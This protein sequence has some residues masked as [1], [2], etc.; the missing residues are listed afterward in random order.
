MVFSKKKKKTD[1]PDIAELSRRIEQ[2]TEEKEFY[3]R[4][5]HSLLVFLK[6][7]PLDLKEVD[8]AGFS[9]HIDELTKRIL[10]VTPPVKSRSFVEKSKKIISNF[11]NRHKQV[12]G[13]RE[14]EFKEIIEL[15]T[16]AM[17]ELGNENRDYH[18]EIYKQTETIEKLTLLDDI[19][20]IKKAIKEQVEHIR[21]KVIEKQEKENRRIESLSEKVS[22]LETELKRA[23]TKSLIDGLTGIY[24]RMAF[25]QKIKEMV[26]K[27]SMG[28]NPF[29]LLL[30]DIDDFKRIN[31]TYGH[32]VGDRVILAV[33]QKTQRFI[34]TGDFAARYGGEEF[35]VILPGA[36]LRSGIKKAK[37]IGKSIASAKYVVSNEKDEKPLGVTVSIGVAFIGKADTVESIIK[38]ADKALYQAKQ[39]GKNKVVSE[40]EI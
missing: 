1:E 35:V 3:H 21:E 14:S 34:R 19:K 36:S 18:D 11:I 9:R 20:V 33:V 40:K 13:E 8:T 39:T 22:S 38:R 37:Q 27:N 15:L 6:T 17:A 25:D 24:N 4:T 30:I 12:L 31:D 28:R 32:P 7:F 26:E 2:H 16:R 5:I 29:S 23:E 10:E